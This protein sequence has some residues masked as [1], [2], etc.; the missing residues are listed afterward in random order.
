MPSSPF[1]TT[2]SQIL[3]LK[4]ILMLIIV[5]LSIMVDKEVFV[6]ATLLDMPLIVPETCQKLI[7]LI[8]ASIMIYKILMRIFM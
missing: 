5:I 3:I 6:P 2:N 4:K 8:R 1:K 7:P